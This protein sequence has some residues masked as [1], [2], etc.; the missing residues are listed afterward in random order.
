MSEK[1]CF[2]LS[3]PLSVK[4]INTKP[5]ISDFIFAQCK[6]CYLPSFVKHKLFYM[7]RYLKS[8]CGK[9]L[10]QKILGPHAIVTVYYITNYQYHKKYEIHCYNTSEHGDNILNSV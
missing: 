3:T 4:K 6:L 7:F 5:C 8:L 9:T 2:L 1:L 10:Q